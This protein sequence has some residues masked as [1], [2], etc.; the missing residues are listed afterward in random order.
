MKKIVFALIALAF[1]VTPCFAKDI[2]YKVL[3]KY[4]NYFTVKIEVKH[5]GVV[6]KGVGRVKDYMIVAMKN[7]TLEF[8]GLEHRIVGGDWKEYTLL[9]FHEPKADKWEKFDIRS[10]IG[11]IYLEVKDGG[12]S[13]GSIW[14]PAK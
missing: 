13:T 8:Q 6:G 7:D 1:V 4:P 9:P 11:T 5:E 2:S 3:Q 14:D 12:K 10:S